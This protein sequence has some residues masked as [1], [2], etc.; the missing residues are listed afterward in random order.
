MVEWLFSIGEML[1]LIFIFIKYF[2]IEKVDIF[3]LILENIIKCNRKI[4][5]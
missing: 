5:L 4:E 1:C 2:V 3:M